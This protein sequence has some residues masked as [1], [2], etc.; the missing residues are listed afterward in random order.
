MKLLMFIRTSET[1]LM[2]IA[3]IRDLAHWDKG[4]LLKYERQKLTADFPSV[5]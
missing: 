4:V 5:H 2:G 3:D 1:E